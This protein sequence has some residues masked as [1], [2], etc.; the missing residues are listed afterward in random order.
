MYKGSLIKKYTDAIMDYR[1]TNGLTEEIAKQL[2]EGFYS[3]ACDSIIIWSSKEHNS[4]EINHIA[5]NIM[6]DVEHNR[7]HEDAV[8]THLEAIYSS[9]ADAIQKENDQPMDKEQAIK[10]AINTIMRDI[11][12]G[13]L[14]E[15]GIRKYLRS[16]YSRFYNPIS[17]PEGLLSRERDVDR[18]TKSIVLDAKHG[19]V[20]EDSLRIYLG[21]LHY[22]AT[23]TRDKDLY[24]DELIF[25]LTDEI[26]DVPSWDYYSILKPS[27]QAL[28]SYAQMYPK[29]KNQLDKTEAINKAIFNFVGDYD[30]LATNHDH[31][32]DVL[33]PH[34]EALYNE[35]KN[36]KP[37]AYASVSVKDV[38]EITALLELTAKQTMLMTSFCELIRESHIGGRRWKIEGE[39]L[40][41]QADEIIAEMAKVVTPK[42]E[43]GKGE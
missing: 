39:K 13:H 19:R 12:L 41:E 26:R 16:F 8:K 10:F 40:C 5:K 23:R 4:D 30:G 32:T 3:E 15:D 11:D 20:T 14:N 6:I 34:L 18:M 9:A 42:Q 2:L 17:V 33:R 7:L 22:D 1:Y 35:A 24:I 25:K 27:L 29:G 43:E 38:P 37:V 28:F 36:G 21:S 31:I